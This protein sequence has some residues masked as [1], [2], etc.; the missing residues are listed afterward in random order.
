[1][2]GERG[3]RGTGAD[4]A[5]RSAA[6]TPGAIP[7][8]MAPAAAIRTKSLLLVAI[9]SLPRGVWF[10]R[11]R[12]GRWARPLPFPALGV[13]A[14]ARGPLVTRGPAAAGG[15]P[16]PVEP[17]VRRKAGPWAKLRSLTF[18]PHAGTHPESRAHPDVSPAGA[19]ARVAMALTGRGHSLFDATT[20]WLRLPGV[21]GS[22]RR[23]WDATLPRTATGGA[24]RRRRQPA[25]PRAGAGTCAAIAGPVYACW[26]ARCRRPSQMAIRSQTTAIGTAVNAMAAMPIPSH[27]MIPYD[28]APTWSPAR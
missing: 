2:R 14:L 22:G 4:D 26:S 28:Q 27:I 15:L 24:F 6:S 5:R 21:G 7:S 3:A 25:H 11:S 13:P 20:G 1:M 23:P 19:P 10:L 9:R 16:R 8:P 17:A 18:A 12:P